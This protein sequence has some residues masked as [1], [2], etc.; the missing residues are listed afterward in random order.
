M[1]G[2]ILR[3]FVTLQGPLVLDV[4]SCV[5]LF[6]TPWTVARQAPLSMGFSRQEYWSG[7]PFPSLGDLPKPRI[8][9]TSPL[10]P[11]LQLDPLP[12]EP[13]LHNAPLHCDLEEI[14]LFFL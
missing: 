8:E 2:K 11:E 3:W 6:E 13:T 1:V 7:L 12:T 14:N 5:Q 9:L 10:S 4:L